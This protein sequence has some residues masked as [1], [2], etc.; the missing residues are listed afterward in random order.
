M[1]SPPPL[2][3]PSSVTNI[4]A[5]IYHLQ[6]DFI[7]ILSDLVDY[8]W[9]SVHQPQSLQISTRVQQGEIWTLTSSYNVLGRAS[10]A[11]RVRSASSFS[12][13]FLSIPSMS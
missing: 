3:G 11:A 10:L 13:S 9:T 7:P 5:L 2:L 4:E 6:T 8:L 12:F 1:S